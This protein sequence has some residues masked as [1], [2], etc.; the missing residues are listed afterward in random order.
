MREGTTEAIAD[1]ERL[2]AVNPNYAIAYNTLGYT[3]SRRRRLREG[4]GLPQAVPLPRSRP[5]EPATTPSASST[6]TPD[7]TTRPRTPQEG[8][9]DQGRTSPGLGHL[10]TVEVGRGNPRRPP[11]LLP[12]GGGEAASL[13]GRVEFRCSRRSRS[14]TRAPGRRA[15]KELDRLPRP[16]APA[17]PPGGGAAAPMRGSRF[18]SAASSRA[19]GE[20]AEADGPA[21]VPARSP[22]EKEP[23]REEEGRTAG[24]P[25]SA[26]LIARRGRRLRRGGRAPPRGAR[27]RRRVRPR[28]IAVLPGERSFPR[29]A[30]RD[31]SS[32]SAGTTRP[33]RSCSR[34]S[35]GT[36]ASPRRS[37]SLA[38]AEHGK[39]GRPRRARSG[40]PLT[41]RWRPAAARAR[42][43]DVRRSRRK[44]CASR[45][46]TTSAAR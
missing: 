38:R 22:D 46:S 20:T 33:R 15:R 39:A 7:G 45:P 30:A 10:G 29:L 27:G 3:A 41:R 4:R 44:S 9:R 19:S 37:P 14:S 6:R 18:I 36:R 42:H 32:S 43:R 2:L 24:D 31:A 16:S 25:W 5:G 28:R 21:R 34:S 12:P 1:Y 23:E 17:L 11:Q 35:T 26:A 13:S 40:R 8:A